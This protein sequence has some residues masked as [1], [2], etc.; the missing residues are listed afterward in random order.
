MTIQIIISQIKLKEINDVDKSK[1]TV[2][3]I[4]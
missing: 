4:K 3:S 2:K 1:K